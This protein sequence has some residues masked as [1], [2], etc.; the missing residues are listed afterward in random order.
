M[1]NPFLVSIVI[2]ANI[3]GISVPEALKDERYL[4]P[5]IISSPTENQASLEWQVKN[6][7][8]TQ[9]PVPIKKD[10]DLG[11]DL[12]ARAG[13]IMDTQTE[14]ILWQKNPDDALPLASLTKLMT[15]LIFLEHQ[16]PAGL[17][18]VHTFAP[19]EDA[20]GKELNLPHGAKLRTFDL[21]R[22]SIVGSDNDTTL[23][24]A[25]ATEMSENIFVDL[26]NKKAHSLGLKQ[27]KFIEPTGL[28]KQNIATPLEIALLAKTAFNHTEI[29]EPATMA[30]HRQKRLDNQEE[31]RVTTT[32]KLLFDKDLKITGGKTGYTLEAGYNVVE[33]AMEPNSG[34]EIIVVVLGASS[35][36][37]RFTEAK[38]LILWTFEHYAYPR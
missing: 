29:Q 26:M 20:G 27:A 12:N 32:N 11:P 3:L 35:D 37:E 23:A 30:D 13:L 18:H 5:T 8:F 9:I 14:Q 36:E 21:L 25:H 34:R 22:S 19:E 31:S 17:E 4:V 2:I 38:K 7:R 28:N 33:Q 15:A 10:N 1:L 16:P 6:K 24:L